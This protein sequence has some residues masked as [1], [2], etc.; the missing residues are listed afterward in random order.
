MLE[1]NPLAYVNKLTAEGERAGNLKKLDLN[2]DEVDHY[3]SK[4]VF[5]TKVV[6]IAITDHRTAA[7]LNNKSVGSATQDVPTTI[8]WDTS[9]NASYAIDIAYEEELH[10][11]G[12]FIHRPKYW[13]LIFTGLQRNSLRTVAILLSL[14]AG[15]NLID[16]SFLCLSLH[17][18]IRLFNALNLRTTKSQTVQI[19]GIIPI[20]VTNGNLHA[21]TSFGV[22]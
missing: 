9:L 3:K 22:V 11:M 5:A 8:I 2:R 15:L 10:G 7:P 12:Y 14:L 6:A 19:D 17:S 20:F 4:K 1:N 13:F 18:H 16:R 21:K